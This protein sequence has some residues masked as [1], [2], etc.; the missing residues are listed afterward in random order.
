[1]PLFRYRTSLFGYLAYKYYLPLM[2]AMIFVIIAVY[3]YVTFAGHG[4]FPYAAVFAGPL[5]IAAAAIF[6]PVVKNIS[7]PLAHVIVCEEGLFIRSHTGK[8][9]VPWKFLRSYHHGSSVKPW[10]IV[11]TYYTGPGKK[12]YRRVNTIVSLE[13]EH[14][15]NEILN[16][17]YK[18]R[19]SEGPEPV[20]V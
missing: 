13:T 4:A 5:Q 19:H 2:L 10:T 6:I 11:L 17:I 8:I 7:L 3:Q 20:R 18:V 1:M 15:A 14:T 12:S 9:F 16:F